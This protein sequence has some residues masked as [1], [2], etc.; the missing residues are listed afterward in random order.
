MRDSSPVPPSSD[1]TLVI[2]HAPSRR[3]A[4]GTEH[5]IAACQ[6]LRSR[7]YDIEL[8]LIEG[9]SHARA[10]EAYRDADIAV[11]QLNVG[12]YGVF[13]VEIMALGKPVVCYID[14][15]HLKR[16]GLDSVP[17]VNAAPDTLASVLASLAERRDELAHLGRLGREYVER[18]HDPRMVA[19]RYA[20]VYAEV[21]RKTSLAWPT[22]GVASESTEVPQ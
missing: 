14:E 4:K 16:A 2:V 12:W 6:S 20:Q 15:Q 11:D 21:A 19:S 1:G 9:M 18:M 10:L 17:V 8:R 13:S 22:A 5:V 7:G 3:S